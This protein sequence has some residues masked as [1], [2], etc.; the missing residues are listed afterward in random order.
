MNELK[1]IGNTSSPP[2]TF[3]HVALEPFPVMATEKTTKSGFTTV[4]QK[5]ELTALHVVFPTEDHRFLAGDLAHV[6]AD[7]FTMP[8]AREIYELDGQK[9]ILAPLNAI[10]VLKRGIKIPHVPSIENHG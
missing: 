3:Q 7:Q 2:W 6:R 10:L 8:W 5:T 9:Y 1:I 4:K